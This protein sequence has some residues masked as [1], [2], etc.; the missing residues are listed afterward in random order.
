MKKYY[1][2]GILGFMV[3]A[4]WLLSVEFVPLLIMMGAMAY[5]IH[6]F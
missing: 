1:M 2:V 4:G 5:V 3:L 6:R